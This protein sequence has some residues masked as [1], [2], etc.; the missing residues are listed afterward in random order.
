MGVATS[1][2][3]SR[4]SRIVSFLQVWNSHGIIRQFNSEGVEDIDIEYH[5]TTRNHG[6]RLN[7]IAGHTMATLTPQAAVLACPRSEDGGP[8]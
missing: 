3:L 6:L 1:A 7:N 8:R 5:D 2:V 4:I